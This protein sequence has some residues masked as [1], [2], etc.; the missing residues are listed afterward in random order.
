MGVAQNHRPPGSDVVDVFFPVGI[1]DMG[2]SATLEKA[3]RAA[4]GTKCA[5]RGIDSAGDGALRALKQLFVF[6]HDKN[7][8]KTKSGCEEKCVWVWPPVP[9][10]TAWKADGHFKALEWHFNRVF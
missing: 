3:R 10:G 1:P 6:G 5:D 9:E 8:D 2:A 4:Y 7:P